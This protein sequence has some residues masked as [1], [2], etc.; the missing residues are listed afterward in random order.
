MARH[1]ETSEDDCGRRWHNQSGRKSNFSLRPEPEECGDGKLIWHREGIF[2]S[3][4]GE[5]GRCN[6]SV[7]LFRDKE[8][9][10]VDA[11]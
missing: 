8:L 10:D 11:D 5:D 6:A 3:R 4:Y 2:T 9:P 1:F 7:V